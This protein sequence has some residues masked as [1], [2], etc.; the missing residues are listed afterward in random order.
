M[1]LA[2]DDDSSLMTV[3]V[4]CYLPQYLLLH[5]YILLLP[6]QIF[7]TTIASHQL[8]HT[9]QA[10]EAMFGY[11]TDLSLVDIDES[12]TVEVEVEG[13]YESIIDTKTPCFT[14]HLAFN[15][16]AQII[17]NLYSCREYQYFPPSIFGYIFI[18]T[19]YLPHTLYMW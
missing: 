14:I 4:G 3:S 8:T 1:I 11:M 5:L 10:T 9:I 12:K 2:N 15:Y 6:R 19:V 17:I 13:L 18:C 7:T 16:T